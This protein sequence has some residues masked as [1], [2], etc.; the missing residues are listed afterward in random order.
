MKKIIILSTVFCVMMVTASG[1]SGAPCRCDSLLEKI[2]KPQLTGDFYINP[3]PGKVSL[4]FSD[5]WLSGSVLLFNQVSVPVNY[6]KYNGYNDRL[7]IMSENYTQIKLDQE[8]IVSFTLLDKNVPGKTYRFDRLRFSSGQTRDSAVFAQLVYKGAVSLY[9]QRK[10][11]KVGTDETIGSR[12]ISDAF[13]KR[14]YYFF[15]E[16]D[17]VTKGFRKINRKGI[18]EVLPAEKE[19]IV[20]MMRSPGRIRVKTEDDLVRFTEWLNTTRQTERKDKAL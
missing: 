17:K 14:N 13:E 8:P 6:M 10:V 19:S 11:V 5:H 2:R 4:F 3:I 1:Q 18:V 9:V 12:I 15:K 16:G 7:I 20:R